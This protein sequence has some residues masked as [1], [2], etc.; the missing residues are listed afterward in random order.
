MKWAGFRASTTSIAPCVGTMGG[1][2]DYGGW[3][4]SLSLWPP[5][6]PGQAVLLVLPGNGRHVDPP[7]A[8]KTTN[9]LLP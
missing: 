4:A 3:W 1:S 8:A 2:H 6:F 7:G 9:V 5:S